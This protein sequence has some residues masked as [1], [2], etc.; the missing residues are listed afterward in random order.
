MTRKVS[1]IL[2]LV[3]NGNYTDAYD[4]LRNGVQ[5]KT[6]GCATTGQADK[7]D[8]I[9]PCEHQAPVYNL[10]NETLALLDNLL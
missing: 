5:K 3:S 10:V 1:S 9:I 8:W 4:Q 2:L 6:E 7:S